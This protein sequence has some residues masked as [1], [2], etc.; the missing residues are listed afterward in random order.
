MTMSD[1]I[2]KFGV[3]PFKILNFPPTNYFSNLNCRKFCGLS[4]ES[5]LV[6][7]RLIVTA[8]ELLT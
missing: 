2:L 1:S 8:Q 4:G 3:C 7:L 6:V 5:T